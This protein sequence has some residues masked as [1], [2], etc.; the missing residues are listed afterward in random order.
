MDIADP[1]LR[2][3]RATRCDHANCVEIAEAQDYVHMRDSKASGSA[4]VLTFTQAEWRS[5]IA[6]TKAGEFDR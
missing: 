1:S 3:R 5:F 6:A 4:P 2:W